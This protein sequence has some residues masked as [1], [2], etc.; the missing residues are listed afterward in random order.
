MITGTSNRV[1]IRMG[2]IAIFFGVKNTRLTNQKLCY[3]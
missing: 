2:Q 1:R 3:W